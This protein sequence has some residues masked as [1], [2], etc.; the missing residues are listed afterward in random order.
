[1]KKQIRDMNL[2]ELGGL[3]CDAL[4]V[5]GI[6]VVLSGGSCV[7]IYSRGEYTSWDLDLITNI[8]NS[9]KKFVP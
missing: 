9:L 6:H 1:M 7:E 5:Q 8:M 2:K 3:I 4:I